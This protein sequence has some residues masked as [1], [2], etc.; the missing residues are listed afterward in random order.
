MKIPLAGKLIRGCALLVCAGFAMTLGH[1]QELE[2]VR[3]ARF[4]QLS[5]EALPSEWKKVGKNLVQAKFRV[6]PDFLHR[7]YPKP[8]DDPFDGGE[9]RQLVTPQQVLEGVGIP[10]G[11]GASATYFKDRSSSSS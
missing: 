6:P 8:V 5:H 7:G 10:F 9:S 4:A 1:A 3:D 11:E 2:I